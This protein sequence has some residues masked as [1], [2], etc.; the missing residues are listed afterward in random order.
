MHQA[1]EGAG[2]AI[3]HERS[4][5]SASRTV[6]V[7]IGAHRYRV[8]ARLG[9]YRSGPGARAYAIM[10]AAIVVAILVMMLVSRSLGAFIERHPTIKMLALAFLHA[11]RRRRSSPK[12]CIF[13][14]PKGYLYFAMAFSVG[15]E[16]STQPACAAWTSGAG[17]E[18]AAARACASGVRG[19]S[20]QAAVSVAVED[21]D[22]A[23]RSRSRRR[24]ATSWS[25][26]AI[27]SCAPHTSAPAMQMNQ[28]AGVRNGRGRSGRVWRSTSTPMHTVTNALSVPIDTSSAEDL[29]RKQTAD[30]R[31]ADAPVTSCA[32]RGRAELRMHASEHRRQQSIARHGEEDARLRDRHHQHDRG[33][34][35]RQ[36]PASPGCRASAASCTCRAR[37]RRGPRRRGP[38]SSPCR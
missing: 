3:R 34:A 1:L 29:D 21:V 19:G 9:V 27:P 35:G 6:I 37:E 23:R 15:V 10:V 11:H 22:Q 25:L 31:G 16:L 24:A 33:H 17:T 32:R 14:I 38:C 12:D 8:L 7:Q 36:R 30:Y 20:S 5:V 26:R 13:E 18:G 28:G 2:R 4:C